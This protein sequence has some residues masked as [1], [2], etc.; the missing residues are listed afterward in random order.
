MDLSCAFVQLMIKTICWILW[1]LNVV[2]AHFACTMTSS[3]VQITFPYYENKWPVFMRE[4]MCLP[5]FCPS[6]PLGWRHLRM[7]LCYIKLTVFVA[8]LFFSHANTF[9][10][11]SRALIQFYLFVGSFLFI[12]FVARIK[13]LRRFLVRPC[14]LIYCQW[15]N[16]AAFLHI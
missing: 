4:C 2:F 7:V 9:A 5:H 1:R 15:Y 3:I 11:I 12:F 14:F 16:N 6:F 13:F 8:S 10:Q